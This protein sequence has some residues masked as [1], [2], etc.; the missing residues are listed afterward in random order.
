VSGSDGAASWNIFSAGHR[1][2]LNLETGEDTLDAR[3][4][5]AILTALDQYS[6]RQEMLQPNPY[7]GPQTFETK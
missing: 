2:Q 5:V 4:I 7:D 3:E 1:Q 6:L